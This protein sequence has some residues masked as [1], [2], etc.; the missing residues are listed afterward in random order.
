MET[1]TPFDSPALRAQSEF[2]PPSWKNRVPLRVRMC[3]TIAST[4]PKPPASDA[5]DLIAFEG[6]EYEV[7]VAQSGAIFAILP[8]GLLGLRPYEFQVVAWHPSDI[9]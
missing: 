2:Y 6:Q 5:P 4:W 8:Q 3:A 1:K 9:R 7:Y